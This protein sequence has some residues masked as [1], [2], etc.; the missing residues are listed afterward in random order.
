MRIHAARD[1][2]ALQLADERR[3]DVAAAR[4]V[5]DE[6]R[7]GVARDLAFEVVGV[8]LQELRFAL[9]RGKHGRDD[10][11]AAQAA[12]GG[13]AVDGARFGDDVGFLCHV[14]PFFGFVFEKSLRAGGGCAAPARAIGQSSKRASSPEGSGAAG[15]IARVT[16]K[17][18]S[19][20]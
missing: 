12:R 20:A 15:A 18:R 14:W 9:G 7:V 16:P 10:A 2:V 11:A 6:L 13:G 8:E 5:R 17:N 3:A 4:D 1:A 19:E